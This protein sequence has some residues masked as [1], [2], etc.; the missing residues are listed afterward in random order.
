MKLFKIAKSLKKRWLISQGL[1]SED[2]EFTCPHCSKNLIVAVEGGGKTFNCPDCQQPVKVPTLSEQQN[3]FNVVEDSGKEI[4]LPDLQEK[5]GLFRSKNT[6]KEKDKL[7]NVEAAQNKQTSPEILARLLSYNR[8]D[9]VSCLAVENQNC[10]PDLVAKVAKRAI[11]SEATVPI[12]L[13]MYALRNPVCPPNILSEVATR[14]K[15]ASLQ[16]AALDNPNMDV[17]TLSVLDKKANDDLRAMIVKSPNCPEDIINKA[18]LGKRDSRAAIIAAASKKCSEKTLVSILSTFISDTLSFAA[19]RNP[20]C[21]SEIL[22]AILMRNEDDNLSKW[23]AV[24]F[25]LD[26]NTMRLVLQRNQ[27]DA[28]SKSIA[29]RQNCPQDAKTAWRDATGQNRKL[30]ESH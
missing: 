26:E 18:A 27:L 21:S 2:I 10:P 19:I 8:T 23:A 24:S 16:E 9:L 12:T 1:N 22:S 15:V 14:S 4:S 11:G 28:V 13:V 7:Y 29:S 30:K 6:P 5:G 17:G 25:K 20:N 3:K